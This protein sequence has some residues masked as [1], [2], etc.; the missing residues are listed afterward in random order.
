MTNAS[1]AIGREGIQ[2][3]RSPTSSRLRLEAA[4]FLPKGREEVFSFFADPHQLEKITPPWLRFKVLS[5]NSI[6]IKQGQLIEYRLRLHGLPL[7][8]QSR[9]EVWEPPVRFVDVQTRGPYLHWRHEHLFEEA[10]G[11][12]LCRDVVDYAVPGGRVVERFI[13]RRDLRRIF[14]YRQRTL[15]RH[16]AGPPERHLPS[17]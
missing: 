5:A 4:V 11:G 10:P 6:P 8:W 17:A 12:V 2:F 9:I 3:G 1:S 16:F 15:K 14:E 13:V 7:R